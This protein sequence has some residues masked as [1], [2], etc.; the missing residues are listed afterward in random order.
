[1]D[2]ANRYND[3]SGN[4]YHFAVVVDGEEPVFETDGTHEYL[5]MDGRFILITNISGGLTLSGNWTWFFAV[6]LEQK[7]AL[8]AYLP[9][10]EDMTVRSLEVL[11]YSD[12]AELSLWSNTDVSLYFALTQ[13]T[14][15]KLLKR[16]FK[17]QMPTEQ[18]TPKTL[19][20]QSSRSMD[21]MQNDKKLV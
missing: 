15:A 11:A 2:R 12:V 20:S 14:F 21:F 10:D 5:L 19:K 7:G 16:K 1:M 8:W 3:T 6:K 17:L 9:S 18:K 13:I 4:G